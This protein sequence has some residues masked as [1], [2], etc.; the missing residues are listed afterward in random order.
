MTIETNYR[1]NEALRN[2]FN[3]LAGKIFGG[4]N[5]ENW[6]RNGFWKD[7]Y[8]GANSSSGSGAVSGGA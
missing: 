2:S 1:D 5:F 6:Y 4:L 3:E 7:N 8:T